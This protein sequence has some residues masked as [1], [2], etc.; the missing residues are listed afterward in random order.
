VTL[1]LHEVL[2]FFESDA[3]PLPK[4]EGPP[5]DE[6]PCVRARFTP[7]IAEAATLE[8]L[9]TRRSLDTAT[10]ARICGRTEPVVLGHLHA[11]HEMGYV[12]RSRGRGHAQGR[13]AYLWRRARGASDA[14]RKMTLHRGA[15]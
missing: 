4:R 5:L 2:C 9:P 6:V 3:K 8:M 13:E 10:V 14:V 12:E 11:L 1:A 15:P 7:T